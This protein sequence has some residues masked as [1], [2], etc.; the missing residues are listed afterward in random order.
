MFAGDRLRLVA[1]GRRVAFGQPGE[2]DVSE[3]HTEFA[4]MPGRVLLQDF[5]GVPCVVA[6][7]AL[8]SALARLGRDPKVINPSVPVDLVIRGCPPMPK[9]LLQGLLSLLTK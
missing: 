1:T 5:T 4:F 3:V 2:R 6:L 7:A 8:R 9:Q